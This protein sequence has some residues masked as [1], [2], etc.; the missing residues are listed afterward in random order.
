MDSSSYKEIY[1]QQMI[2]WGE[3]I[4]DRDPAYF[5]QLATK[6]AIKPV[7]LIVD[8]RRPS[9]MNYFKSEYMGHTLTVRV[10]ACEDVRAVRGWVFTEGVDDA[11][12]ECALDT[13]PV[14]M[15]INNNTAEELETQL[16]AIRTRVQLIL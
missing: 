1:R 3:E 6:E 14:D 15:V 16:E 13:Y 11:P 5:C 8:A 10:V 2:V 12:S 4:R 9:D 7:W